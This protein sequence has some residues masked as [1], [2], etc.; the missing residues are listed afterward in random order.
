MKFD[1]TD[2]KILEILQSQGRITNTRLASMVGISQPAMLE[3]VRRLE[4]F[5]VISGYNA[6]LDP[7]KL[8]LEILAFVSVSV[9]I[10]QSSPVENIK[11]KIS[12]LPEVLE[13]Y[14]TSGDDDLII[15]VAVK[16]IH[17]YTDWIMNRLSKIHGIRKIKTSFVISTVKKSSD[18]HLGALVGRTV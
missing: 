7:Q 17:C 8:G 13:C 14:Q 4:T 15:K 1:E 2:R 18:Y 6:V 10:H 16:D 3:R 9:A 5:G 11:K 12:E